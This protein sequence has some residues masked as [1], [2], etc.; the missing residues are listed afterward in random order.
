MTAKAL[1]DFV[2]STVPDEAR[3]L[4]GEIQELNP[5]ELIM[6]LDPKP[7]MLRP[8]GIIT[9]PTLFGLADF[10]SFAAVI[11]H[12]GLN[13][14]IVTNSGTIMYLRPAK[15]KRLYARVTVTK[16]G[17]SFATT[18]VDLWQSHE[19]RRVAQ[20]M[21]SFHI[22]KTFPEETLRPNL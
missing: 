7:A 11:G 22:P 1:A 6:F 9:G 14:M 17:R 8:G 5:G 21:T 13:K 10:A 18:A 20:A 12:I 19:D 3:E 2:F 15:W 16:L 4:Y